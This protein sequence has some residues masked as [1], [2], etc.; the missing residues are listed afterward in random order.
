MQTPN[1]KHPQYTH[2]HTHKVITYPEIKSKAYSSSAYFF[3]RV[4]SELPMNILAAV[5]YSSIIYWVVGLNKDPLRFL[6]FVA[7]I[8]L[9]TCASVGIGFA[10]SA[11]T[12]NAA[13]A[14]AIGPPII[15]ICILFGGFYVNSK[16]IPQGA[17]WVSYISPIYWTFSGLVLNEFSG[18]QFL[19]PPTPAPLQTQM[20]N[21]CLHVGEQVIVRLG[22]QNLTVD[23]CF[24]ALAVFFVV[25][26]L[27]AYLLLAINVRS[28]EMAMKSPRTK[29][30]IGGKVGRG[31]RGRGGGRGEGEGGERGGEEGSV[32]TDDEW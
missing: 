10:V 17:A 24:L 7:F 30:A 14:N 5:V 12:K 2:T 29:N 26:S 23:L 4:L 8:V 20:N 16:T 32:G 6:I 3:S 9:E 21:G 15:I 22:F 11:G 28:S 1:T 19:C 13:I 27:L 25:I 18:E 31:G